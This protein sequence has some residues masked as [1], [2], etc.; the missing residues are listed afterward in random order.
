[1]GKETVQQTLVYRTDSK[2]LIFKQKK[3]ALSWFFC[4]IKIST[5]N[6]INSLRFSNTL[7]IPLIFVPPAVA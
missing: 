7:L 2:K 4:F 1:M 3:P 5:D 6:Y